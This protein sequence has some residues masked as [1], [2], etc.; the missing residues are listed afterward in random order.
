M[1]AVN[2]RF[3]YNKKIKS[4][5]S[6]GWDAYTWAASHFSPHVCAPYLKVIRHW[7]LCLVLI[8]YLTWDTKVEKAIKLSDKDYYEPLDEGESYERNGVPR[9]LDDREYLHIDKMR[10]QKLTV[11]SC[12]LTSV[13]TYG[14]NGSLTQHSIFPDLSEMLVVQSNVEDNKIHSVKLSKQP[15]SN[16]W[17]TSEIVLIHDKNGSLTNIK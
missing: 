13:T 15:A 9:F 16:E 1:L 12:T 5:A 14:R 6:A 4:P 8:R 17:E 2:I 7:R 3:V 10:I 11:I